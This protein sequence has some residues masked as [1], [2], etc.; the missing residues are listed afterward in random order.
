MR[1]RPSVL[2]FSAAV[3]SGSIGAV[4]QAPPTAQI[5]GAAPTGALQSAPPASTTLRLRGTIERYEPSTRILSLSTSN[6][7]V[8]LSVA[9]TARILQGSQQLS[10][11]A[12][13]QLSLYRAVVRY[14]DSDGHKTVDSVHVIGKIERKQ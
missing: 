14:S 7:T 1:K 8:Q 10:V 5:D 2:L 13:E 9:S 3:T 4:A 11:S 6:R 12:L